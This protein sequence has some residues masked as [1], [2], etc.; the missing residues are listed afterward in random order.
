MTQTHP[1]SLENRHL[2]PSPVQL[3]LHG[4]MAFPLAFA[5]LPIYL[6]APD[7]YAT[8]LGVPLTTLGLVLLVL[9]LIDAVQD[10]LIGLIGDRYP[11]H[12]QLLLLSGV[13]GL[14]AGLTMLFHPL[15]SAP[16]TWFALSVLLCTTGFSIVTIFLQTL[17]GL[18]DVA[19][20]ERSRITSWREAIG[21]LGLLTAAAGPALLGVSSNPQRAFHLYSLYYLPILA[22]ATAALLYWTTQVRLL[23][24]QQD[25]ND[26]AKKL[27]QWRDIF[28]HPWRRRFFALY[29]LN[30][31]A[32]AIP[33]V[34]VLFFI[35]DRLE[36]EAAT[37]T[38]LMIYFLSGAGSMPIW[39]F[40]ATRLG[41]YRAWGGSMGVAIVTFIW[42][43]FLGP[44]DLFAYGVI[45]ALSGLALGADLALPPA[46]LA[47]H[48]N[49]SAGS[50]EA[51]RLFSVT[52][53][54]TKTSLACATGLVL[55]LLGFAGYQ[56]GEALPM[57]LGPLLNITYATL[58]C[59]LKILCLVMLLRW[60]GGGT[61]RSALFDTPV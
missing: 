8:A 13:V 51:S 41:K 7:F 61:A 56:P 24:Q 47:D 43:S 32:S 16:I 9:R 55:P 29:G 14:G 27:L 12:R 4:A 42:A 44:G 22:V 23:S 35:R 31:L 39:H 11:Q 15:H 37:G 58:P 3:A 30:T 48:I 17:G 18:W 46:I 53:L 52:T 54:T 38:F 60:Q 25:K 6:H 1:R 19:E 57:G 36:A 2:K 50:R 5:G 28:S 59:C 40:V 33:A 21:L 45:C 34:L 49:D 10:P 20:V 26:H